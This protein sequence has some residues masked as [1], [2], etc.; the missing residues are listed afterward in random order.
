MTMKRWVQQILVLTAWFVNVL[1][2]FWVMVVLRQA[3]LSSL[4]AWY[5]GDSMPRAWRARFY[6]RAYFVIAGLVYLIL[7]FVIDG[8]LRDGLAKGDTFRRFVQ[9]T[10]IALLILFP[11][12]LLNSLVQGS[13]RSSGLGQLSLALAALELLG[14]AG[15]LAYAIRRNPKR[16]RQLT[17]GEMT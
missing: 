4:A 6:D 2:A 9:V 12:D 14:G 10:A 5:V 13:T 8:Y 11:A 16:R 3:L 17:R 1:L 7:T 15:L